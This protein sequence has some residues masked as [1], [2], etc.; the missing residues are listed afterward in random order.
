MNNHQI[1]LALYKG[2]RDGTG[3]R[4]WVARFTDGLTRVLTR[5]R[6]SHCEIAVREHTQAS[7]YT[8]YSASIRDGGV[9]CKVMP[10]PEAKWDLIPL[11]STPEAHEQLQ[12][13]WTATEGQGYD[14]RGALG[15][16]FGLPQNRR[17]WFC[18]EWCAA[19]LGL[20]AGWR[21][22]PNDLAAIVSVLKREA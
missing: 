5:G 1:Y 9:R 18:S 4:V 8:C 16:A 15:I 22:S 19:A 14:L 10:L 20:P 7:V 17:R 12:R 2:R 11:P 6:Y 3:W 21:W 13:V